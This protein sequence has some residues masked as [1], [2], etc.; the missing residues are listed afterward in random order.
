MM[1]IMSG[2]L[3]DLILG[4]LFFVH[5]KKR[6]TRP[7]STTAGRNYRPQCRIWLW[8]AR[9]SHGSWGM[10]KSGRAPDLASGSKRWGLFF[11]KLKIWVIRF[12]Q[13]AKIYF[14]WEKI[15]KLLSIYI[16]S[17]LQSTLP[18]VYTQ[19]PSKFKMKTFYC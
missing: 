19:T 5:K 12:Y 10:A 2:S 3:R 16:Y 4:S 1:K 14:S 18:I 17:F 11:L 6:T 8:P 15:S 7:N 9:F 13:A